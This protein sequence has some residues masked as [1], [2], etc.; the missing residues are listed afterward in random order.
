[1]C[2]VIGIVVTNWVSPVAVQRRALPGRNRGSLGV[3]SVAP[4][5]SQA[6][7]WFSK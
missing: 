1:M 6:S 4:S 5:H 7:F 2:D 3:S